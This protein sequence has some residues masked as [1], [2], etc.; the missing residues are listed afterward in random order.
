MVFFVNEKAKSSQDVCRPKN[1]YSQYTDIYIKK[2]NEDR[3]GSV[4]KNLESKIKATGLD[5]EKKLKQC[6]LSGGKAELAYDFIPFVSTVSCAHGVFNFGVDSVFQIGELI[7]QFAGA[8]K[9]DWDQSKERTEKC[10]S[11]SANKLMLYYAYNITTPLLMNVPVPNESSLNNKQCWQIEEELRTTSRYKQRRLESELLP[12]FAK[13]ELKFM[14]K[15]EKEFWQWS[16]PEVSNGV[17]HT[18]LLK[19]AKELIKEKG[20]ELNC[21][22]SYTAQALVCEAVTEAATLLLGSAAGLK[23]LS[24]ADKLL[25][26]GGLQ[27]QTKIVKTVDIAEIKSVNLRYFGKKYGIATEAV[28]MD[29]VKYLRIVPDRNGHWLARIAK[30]YKEKYGTDFLVEDHVTAK[31]NTPAYFSSKISSE[32]RSLNLV[33]RTDLD[34]NDRR[35]AMSIIAHELIHVRSQLTVL[36]VPS[37]SAD[38]PIFFTSTEGKIPIPDY[39][40][41]A[42]TDEVQAYAQSVKVLKTGLKKAQSE[43]DKYA[44]QSIA[45]DIRE[46]VGRAKDHQAYFDE[47]LSQISQ[48]VEKYSLYSP[49]ERKYGLI[50]TTIQTYDKNGNEVMVVFEFPPNTPTDPAAFK[51]ILQERIRR[52]IDKNRKLVNGL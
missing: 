9:V 8:V 20:M 14:S 18:E 26:I 43:N 48:T 16:H 39:A 46:F 34:L 45:S 36:G 27:K 5:P 44:V 25:E 17:G 28:E 10:N 19:K 40:N 4:C 29:G 33:I 31:A 30:T 50:Q 37:T 3:R 6:G 7:G 42:M 15:E 51:K 21:Y 1:F 47:Q 23:K 2:C 11:S 32:S 49:P 38:S 24:R 35:E 22:S 41:F 52:E 12:K 13:G